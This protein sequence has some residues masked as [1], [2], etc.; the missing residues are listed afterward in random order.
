VF[1]ANDV[2]HPLL[3]LK[4]PLTA[5]AAPKRYGKSKSSVGARSP[6]DRAENAPFHSAEIERKT[7]LR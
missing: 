4:K 5:M 1:P 6:N 3:E 2:N 7:V